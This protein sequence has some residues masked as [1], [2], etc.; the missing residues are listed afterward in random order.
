MVFADL[1]SKL[2]VTVFAG[3]ASKL[4]VM[5]FSSLAS[6]LVAMVSPDLAT[7]PM[8]GFLVVPQNEGGGGF[9]GFGLQTG[10]Y[11]LC[12]LGLK[13]TATISWF[14]PQN[15]AGFGLSAA[16]QNLHREVSVG[17]A[18]R[19][20]SLLGVKAN[21]ARVY[22]SDMK[23]GGGTTMGGARCTITEVASEAS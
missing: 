18:S 2:M 12:D 10:S 7:K 3:L 4:V 17:H 5:V 1:A 8:V 22:Q 23:T 19:S 13:I 14:G 6:K 9:S 20:S 11:G 16:P 15:Q 21:L